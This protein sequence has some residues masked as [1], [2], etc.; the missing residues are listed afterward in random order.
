V[1]KVR[2]VKRGRETKKGKGC[3]LCL[4]RREGDNEGERL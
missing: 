1:L 3:V 2:R 4:Q